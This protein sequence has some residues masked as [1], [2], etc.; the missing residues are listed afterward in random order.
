M[1]LLE[2]HD[3]GLRSF[4]E[5]WQ[6][7]KTLVEQRARQLIPDQL[8]LVEHLPVLTCGRSFKPE[9]LREQ[10]QVPLFRIERG[11]DISFHEPGQLVA[12]PI[13]ALPAERR[14]LRAYL[15]MLE[16]TLI[17]TVADFGFCAHSHPE[18]GHTGVWLGERKLA[19]IGIAV[20]RWV[21]WHGLALN[22]N[23]PL[24]LVRGLNPCGF[25]PEVMISMKEAGQREYNM[26]EIKE[27]LQAHFQALLDQL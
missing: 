19:S 22:V 7:Q 18:P 23:N 10:P 27:R 15:S 1:P 24:S 17:L 14:D 2:I 8:L 12:Y 25:A 21:S 11:G 26:N 9:N 4:E 6:L 13:I 16:Q 5:V 3:L 20:R